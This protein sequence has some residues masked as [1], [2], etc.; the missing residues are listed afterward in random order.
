VGEERA[1]V[2]EPLRPGVGGRRWDEAGDGG[3]EEDV[4]EGGRRGEGRSPGPG[5][6]DGEDP[7]EAEPKERQGVDEETL[8]IAAGVRPLGPPAVEEGDAQK[9]GESDRPHPQGAPG[10][11][12][13]GGPGETEGGEKER[14]VEE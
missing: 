3:E 5:R 4:A 11:L 13:D 9:S 2:A 14:R 10:D 6:A 8:A 7:G 12:R 1:V